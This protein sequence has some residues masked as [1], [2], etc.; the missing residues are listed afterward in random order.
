MTMTISCS[1]CGKPIGHAC[2]AC[3]RSRAISLLIWFDESSE[4]HGLRCTLDDVTRAIRDGLD[5]D[6]LAKLLALKR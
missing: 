5:I 3:E 4:A 2:I 6:G 1:G